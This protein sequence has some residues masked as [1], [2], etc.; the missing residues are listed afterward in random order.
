MQLMLSCVII[1]FKGVVGVV[2]GLGDE[3]LAKGFLFNVGVFKG[4]IDIYCNCL[5][6]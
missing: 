1:A 6:V 2:Y 4:L 3:I 5:M